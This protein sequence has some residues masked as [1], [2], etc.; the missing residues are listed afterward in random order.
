MS[1]P[2]WTLLGFCVWTIILLVSTIYLCIAVLAARIMQS[3]VHVCLTQTNTV[4]ALRFVLFFIQIGCFIAL[5][6]LVARH[7]RLVV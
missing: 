4:A 3:L 5:V 7:A 2:I 6:V 1:T